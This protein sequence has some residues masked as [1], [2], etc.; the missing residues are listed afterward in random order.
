MKIL[1]NPESEFAVVV[2]TIGEPRTVVRVAE[3][4]IAEFENE[5]DVSFLRSVLE[6]AKSEMNRTIN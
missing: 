2:D 5:C 1:Y 4:L 6:T 3:C